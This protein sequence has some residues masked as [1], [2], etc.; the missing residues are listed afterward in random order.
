ML[1]SVASPAY[2]FSR[3]LPI[4]GDAQ[5]IQHPRDQHHRGL[6]GRIDVVELTEPGV[7]RMVVDHQALPGRSAAA[8]PA[9]PAAPAEPTSRLTSSSGIGRHAVRPDDQMATGQRAERF[10]N[11]VGFGEGHRDRSCRVGPGPCPR[12]RALPRASA[13][14]WMC[15]TRTMSRALAQQVGRDVQ[16]AGRRVA[17]RGQT[18][19]STLA[20]V[21]QHRWSPDP[22]AAGSSRVPRGYRS[23]RLPVALPAGP[24]GSVITIVSPI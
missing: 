16:F 8:A 7:G 11:A 15:A 2:R 12:P 18:S 21:R 13:S 24:G 4:D 9:N 6:G 3:D 19:P 5:P 10:G 20:H 14:G 17:E 22:G 1:V 23:R